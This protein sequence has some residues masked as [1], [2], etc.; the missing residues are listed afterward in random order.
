[1][2]FLLFLLPVALLAAL[3]DSGSSDDTADD[4]PGEGG[5]VQKG[6]A[7]DNTLAGD[8]GD[9]LLAGFAGD[10]TL[11]GGGGDDL[12]VGDT[13][14]DVLSGGDGVD[15]LLGGSGEDFLSGGAGTDLLIGGPGEDRL[16]GDAGDDLLID[17]NG[18]AEMDGGAGNDTLIGL[19][20]GDDAALFADVTQLESDAFLSEVEA[21]FGAQPDT[22]DRMLLRNVVSPSN[23]PSLDT[24][25]GGIGDD[26]LIGDAGDVMSGGAGADVFSALTSGA[27][28]EPAD[29]AFGQVVRVTDFQIGED[30][31][32]VQYVG[33]E[34]VA[35]GVRAVQGGVMVS[36]NDVDVIFLAGLNA[37]QL[38]PADV[39]FKRIVI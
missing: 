23:E 8:G 3:V 22:F 6:G 18:S 4:A 2:G 34:D 15:V 35:I 38:N 17:F 31:V 10:D 25:A 9:D 1:M 28:V 36:T 13:G 7:G 21:K 26:L 27:P 33:T 39:L 32:E 20:L 37:G 29:P 16:Q 19:A 12:L 11:T 14:D 5:D 30:Q 24:M